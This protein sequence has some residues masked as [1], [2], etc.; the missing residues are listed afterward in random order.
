VATLRLA[1]GAGSAG[2]LVSRQRRAGCLA[3][4]Q[5]VSASVLKGN[6]SPGSS[7]PSAQRASLV[8]SARSAGSVNNANGAW[9]RIV[10]MDCLTPAS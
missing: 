3:V 7:V 9:P 4:A 6:H 8:T 10:T 1:G 5:A 2:L